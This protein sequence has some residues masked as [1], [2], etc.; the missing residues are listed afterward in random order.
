MEIQNTK[1]KRSQQ[2]WDM[3]EVSKMR[4]IFLKDKCTID[5]LA[6]K[7]GRSKKSV[8]RK[9]NHL[10]LKRSSE[11]YIRYNEDFKETVVAY[12]YTTNRKETCERFNISENVLEGFLTRRKRKLNITT[13]T[14]KNEWTTDETLYM[15]RYIGLKPLSY[16]A[17][18]MGRTESALYSHIRRRGYRLS[19]VNGLP[20]ELFDKIFVRTSDMAFMRNFEGEIFIPWTTFEDNL[21]KITNG[22]EFQVIIVRSMAKFQRFLH[23]A[24]NNQ[25][26]K[27]LLWLKIEE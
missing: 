19:Y 7:M 23:G 10:G 14:R 13:T 25:E 16:I 3:V 12:Y 15:L 27:E 11:E 18:Q 21:D 2:F 8:E 1:V 22:D 20:K 5:E 4:S 17:Q 24:K 9:L 6:Q 26:I